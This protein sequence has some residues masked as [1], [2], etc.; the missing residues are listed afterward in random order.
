[1]FLVYHLGLGM[2]AASEAS[3]WPF[4]Q[5]SLFYWS[6]DHCEVLLTA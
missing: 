5:K 6:R 2:G 1:M 3:T 4:V